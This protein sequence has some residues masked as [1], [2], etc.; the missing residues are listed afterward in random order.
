MK[1]KVVLHS[2]KSDVEKES[3]S[4]TLHDFEKDKK[5]ADWKDKPELTH[6]E[7]EDAMVEAVKHAPKI[8]FGK[9]FDAVKDVHQSTLPKKKMLKDVL[10]SI[11]DGMNN[12]DHVV[13]EEDSIMEHQNK[14]AHDY[15]DIKPEEYE[16]NSEESIESLL[17]KTSKLKALEISMKEK[18]DEIDG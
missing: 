2:I 3:K 14:I 18:E 12:K 4:H 1:A 8:G 6:Q 5:A 10:G 15:E 16:S 9:L 13:N 11:K 7:K 17:K